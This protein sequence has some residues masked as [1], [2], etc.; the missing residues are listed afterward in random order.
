VAAFV[1]E[2]PAD[3]FVEDLFPSLAWAAT[4][5]LADPVMSSRLVER[6][7]RQAWDERAR[8]A[9]PELLY[10]HVRHAARV[11]IE[12][13]AERRLATVRFDDAAPML[14]PG[15]LHAMTVQ[16]VQRRLQAMTSTTAAVARAVPAPTAA[17]VAALPAPVQPRETAALA[18]ASAAASVTESRATVT[19]PSAQPPV[20]APVE[21]SAPVPAAK[22][23][24][25]PSVAAPSVAAPSAAAPSV[26]A[27]SA[28]APSAVVPATGEPR[29]MVARWAAKSAAAA[30]ASGAADATGA[31]A[32]KASGAPSAPRG[33][34]PFKG[35]PV[36]AAHDLAREGGVQMSPRIMG[37]IGV[38]VVVALIAAW[39]ALG[40]TPA[41][42]LAI[43]ALADTSGV[44]SATKQAEELDVALPGGGSVHLGSDATLRSSGEFADGARALRITGP[45]IVRMA[46]DSTKPTAIASGTLRWL[47]YGVSAA[48]DRV[49][50]NLLVQVDSGALELVGD[51]TRTRVSAGSSVRVDASAVVTAL[52]AAERDEAFAWRTGRLSLTRAS[53]QRIVDEVRQWF[54]LAVRFAPALTAAESL[55]VNVPLRAVDSL[56]AA[57]GVAVGG[58]VERDGEQLTVS[59][60]PPPPPPVVAPKRVSARRA[61][62]GAT[63]ASR[64]AA[65]QGTASVE[66]ADIRLPELKLLTPPAKPPM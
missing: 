10:E 36:H 21:R 17:P 55:S 32:P 9:T 33:R 41:D 11:A 1:V 7:L 15:D 53:D 8:F 60:A 44:V 66:L 59:A 25:A 29:P 58:T 26:A 65:R 39:R 45:V 64:P 57:L 40:S 42:E 5:R 49:G 46:V 50:N 2:L 28:A 63:S 16:S 18:A 43:A 48:F 20:A 38:I 31:A 23:V 27:P 13:E 22:P 61:R 56:S 24:A 35:S 3:R 34:T 14:V 37:G 62:S 30:P 6:V 52:S 51:S 19:A 47:T 54:G 4:V 12:R